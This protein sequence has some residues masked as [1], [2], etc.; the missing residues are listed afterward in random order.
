MGTPYVAP[1][2]TAPRVRHPP[3]RSGHKIHTMYNTYYIA[4]VQIIA[5]SLSEAY[6]YYRNNC[7]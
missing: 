6:A 4:G 1:P 7:K 2:P 5:K 3:S